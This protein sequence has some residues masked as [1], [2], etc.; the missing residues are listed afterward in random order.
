VPGNII[1]GDRKDETVMR[2]LR[3]LPTLLLLVLSGMAPAAAQTESRPERLVVGTKVAPP[4]AIKNDDGTWSGISIELWREIA[5]ELDLAYDFQEFDLQGLLSAVES[6]T[7]GAAVAA[8]TITSDR[9]RRFDFS[10]PFHTSGLGIAVRSGSKAGL[11]ATVA[12]LFSIGFLHAVGALGLLLLGVGVLIWL[13]ERKRNPAHFGGSAAHGIGAGF[14]WSAVTMTT[15]GYGDKAPLTL[16]GRFVGL[17]WMFAG[18]IMI[19]GFTAAI[20]S[21]LTATRL[22]SEVRGPEDLRNVRVVCTPGSTSAEY[23]RRARTS[24]KAV[25]NPAIGLRA[26]ADGS[27][28]ALVY[29]APILRYLVNSN[30]EGVLN[31][32]PQTFERQDYGIALPQGSPLREAVNRSLLKEIR[33]SKWQDLLFQYLGR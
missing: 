28:D 12:R 16:W 9:E 33:G 1:I 20:A 14:W 4:F 2:P 5:Q 23:L 6:G 17:I 7:V 11:G 13:L 31:V 18:I 25:E 27:A 22:A 24:Y 32:L 10:H 26:V 3:F 21:S 30:Y 19:S 29:D 15:V 8:L